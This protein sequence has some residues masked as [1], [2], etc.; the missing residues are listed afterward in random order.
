M[1]KFIRLQD[2]AGYTIWLNVN[3]IISI[4]EEGT[5]YSRIKYSNKN[6]NDCENTL[7]VEYTPNELL[8]KIEASKIL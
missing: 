8:S 6:D 5:K 7:I 3:H 1:V 2:I 4:Q